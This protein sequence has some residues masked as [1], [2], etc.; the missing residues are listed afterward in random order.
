MMYLLLGIA[1][2]AFLAHDWY[3]GNLGGALKRVK[4]VYGTLLLLSAYHLLIFKGWIYSYSFYDAASLVYGN[5]VEAI[6]AYLKP[7]G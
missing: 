5:A 4:L 1:F 3:A 7:E 2:I 6:F